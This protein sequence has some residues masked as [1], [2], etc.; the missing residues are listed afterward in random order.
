MPPRSIP[1]TSIGIYAWL[2]GQ[3]AGLYFGG[4][5]FALWV[6]AGWLLAMALWVVD[7]RMGAGSRPAAGMSHWGQAAVYTLFLHWVAVVVLV[8]EIVRKKRGR[9]GGPAG[10]PDGGG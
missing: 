3:F 9:A 10:D 5:T 7:Q 2:L 6:W 4:V 8:R 1:W